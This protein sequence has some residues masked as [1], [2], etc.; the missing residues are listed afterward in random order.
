MNPAVLDAFALIICAA[1]GPP[2]YPGIPN[3][4][5]DL[6]AT[7]SHR[8]AIEKAMKEIRK[9]LPSVGSY[10]ADSDFFDEAWR[11]SFWGPNYARLLA[12]KDRYDPDGLFFAHHGVAA[13]AGAPTASRAWLDTGAWPIGGVDSRPAPRDP[14][15]SK[16]LALS[17][18]WTNHYETM[19]AA[20]NCRCCR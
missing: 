7:H 15:A 11:E 3:H 6:L 19:G 4:E 1:A 9:V 12:V 20:V 17:A 16:R 5:P 2:A 10:V 8:E 13:N 18:R 14:W